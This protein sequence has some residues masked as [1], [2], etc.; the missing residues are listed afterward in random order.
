MYHKSSEM[1]ENKLSGHVG[2]IRRGT[3]NTHAISFATRRLYTILDEYDPK[4][5]P[6]GF[7]VG[8]IRMFGK[9]PYARVPPL[10]SEIKRFSMAIPL[11]KKNKSIGTYNKLTT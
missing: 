2:S 7:F 10:C 6:L 8:F 3:Y 9:L 1:T 11:P 5:G 4:L